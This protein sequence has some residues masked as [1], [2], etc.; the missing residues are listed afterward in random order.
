MLALALADD[1]W[2]TFMVGFNILNQTARMRVFAGAAGKGIGI[3]NMFAI[4][5][6]LSRPERLPGLLADLSRRG[7]I[8]ADALPDDEPLGFLVGDGH[9]GSIQEAAYRFCRH[10]PGVHVVLSGTGS[11][12]HVE[13]NARSIEGPPLPRPVVE[14]LR[15]IFARVDD[16]VGN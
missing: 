6:A 14:R 3:M 2:D 9:A 4:K 11:L 16:V 10:E 8:D 7:R 5:E 12:E 15:S 1:C 13:D